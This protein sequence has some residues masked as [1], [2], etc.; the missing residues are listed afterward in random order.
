[1]LH[2]LL[3]ILIFCVCA[4]LVVICLPLIMMVGVI[5]G[6]VA[7]IVIG[8]MVLLPSTA[9]APVPPQAR[10]QVVTQSAPLVLKSTRNITCTPTSCVWQWAGR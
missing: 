8:F 4:Y 2:M 10:V 5:G 3:S 1:V 9:P 7:V 6:V